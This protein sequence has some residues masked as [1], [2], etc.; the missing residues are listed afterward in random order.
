MDWGATSTICAVNWDQCW[1]PGNAAHHERER[2][3]LLAENSV[4]SER[5]A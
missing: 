4:L 5:R 1:L 3:G 2:G